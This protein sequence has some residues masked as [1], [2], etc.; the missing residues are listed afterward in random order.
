MVEISKT[1]FKSDIPH[2]HFCSSVNEAAYQIKTGTKIRVPRIISI[3][4]LVRID[5]G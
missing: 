2:N 3:V 4:V 5:A 1:F